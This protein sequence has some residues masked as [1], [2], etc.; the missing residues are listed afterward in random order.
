[1]SGALLVERN[2]LG[3]RFDPRTASRL[4]RQEEQ[5]NPLFLDTG[6]IG[7]VAAG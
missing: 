7:N 2:V 5:G 1:V 4:S 6:V 3:W